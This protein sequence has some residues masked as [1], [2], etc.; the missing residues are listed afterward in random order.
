MPCSIS[1]TRFWIFS[2]IEAGKFELDPME[3][4]LREDV[5][6]ALKLLAVRAHKKGLELTYDVPPSVPERLVGD[7]PRLRQILINLAG[8]AVKFTERARSVVRCDG[9]ITG[10]TGHP[11]P[12][13][14]RRHR[15]WHPG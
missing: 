6:D 15:H 11:A 8:N 14:R 3:F 5:G 7:S 4:R 2:R 1:S 12:F 9:R 13:H 10:R